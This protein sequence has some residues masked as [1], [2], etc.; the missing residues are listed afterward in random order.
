MKTTIES[1]LKTAKKANK[2][3]TADRKKFKTKISSFLKLKKNRRYSCYISEGV[4]FEERFCR[5]I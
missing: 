4:L 5:K 3:E 2:N 1:I